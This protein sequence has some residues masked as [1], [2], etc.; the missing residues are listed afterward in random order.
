MQ[1]LEVSETPPFAGLGFSN[2]SSGWLL[3]PDWELKLLFYT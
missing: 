3:G 2:T 1:E